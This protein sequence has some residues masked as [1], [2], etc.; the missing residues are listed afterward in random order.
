[1]IEELKLFGGAFSASNSNTKLARHASVGAGKD[2]ENGS[3]GGGKN[4]KG[5]A[6]DRRRETRIEKINSK[7]DKEKEGEKA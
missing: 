5:G 4:R 7:R 1:M 6:S 3:E 2:S